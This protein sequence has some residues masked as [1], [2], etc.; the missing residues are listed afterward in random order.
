M[1]TQRVPAESSSAQNFHPELGY[2]C[3]TPRMR[4]NFRSAV[5]TVAA[6]MAIVAG[7]TLALS[8]QLA[9]QGEAAPKLAM[10][11]VEPLAVADP[12]AGLGQVS[13]PATTLPTTPATG[14]L[15]AGRGRSVCDDLSGA[16]L[17]PR[18]QAGKAGKS[19][20]AR[21]ARAASARAAAISTG[22]AD[23]GP[24]PITA[25]A[26]GPAT[27][28]DEAAV[29]QPAERPVP[30]KKPVKTAN[31]PMPGRDVASAEAAPAVPAPSSGLFG[32]LHA[33][34]RTGSGAWAM[35]W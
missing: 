31:K 29:A 2:F 6:G 34:T 13:V 12:P 28:A 14:E 21:T 30:A 18:C 10:S 17:A 1:F 26:A 35:S 4:R 9:P 7:A 23:A 33:P 5:I 15:A 27:A 8:P 20:M 16:F 19:R 11:P 32:L 3:P 22:G 24:Q 25:A